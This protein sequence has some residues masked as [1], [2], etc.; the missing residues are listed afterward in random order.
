M[1]LK[2]KTKF[3]EQFLSYVLFFFVFWNEYRVDAVFIFQCDTP[4]IERSIIKNE[5]HLA[6]KIVLFRPF[7][8]TESSRICLG[9]ARN[10]QKIMLLLLFMQCYM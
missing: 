6:T 7:L 1:G 4:I 8:G 10:A 2:I 5:L 9:H 3:I